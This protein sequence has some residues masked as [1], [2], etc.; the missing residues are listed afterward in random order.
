[1]QSLN[2][3]TCHD[4]FSLRDLFSYGQKHNLANGENN[5]DGHNGN[6]NRNYGCEGSTENLEI[7]RLRVQMAKNHLATLFLSLGTPMLRAGD[8]LGKTQSGNN[9]AYCQ[10]NQISWLQYK[11]SEDDTEFS[12]YSG[13]QGFVTQLIAIRQQF[14][15]LRRSNF[16]SEWEVRWYGFT[17]C[18]GLF[19]LQS[20]EHW[21]VLV[22]YRS[23]LSFLL[24]GSLDYSESPC[25]SLFCIFNGSEQKLA[26]LLP[27]S[28]LQKN[29]DYENCWQRI[30]DT[31]LD[32]DIWL[33]YKKTTKNELCE[34]SDEK[35]NPP[36]LQHYT[37]APQSV[38]TFTDS[39][40]LY[41][42][43]SFE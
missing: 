38:V 31:H 1:M 24:K 21:Q 3:I 27:Q 19:Q 43:Q 40:L 28:P 16:L 9:K 29:N 35:P 13:L 10:D 34:E 32:D 6:F 12:A 42:K 7:I 8:E 20:P 11:V 30:V 26:L 4:G 14:S 36:A 15:V 22:R 25:S 18:G 41:S 2:F 17:E 5:R 39:L 23:C 33:P 37:V